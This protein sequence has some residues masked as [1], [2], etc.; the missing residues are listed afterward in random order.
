MQYLVTGGC[1]FI[2]SHFISLLLDKDASAELTNIDLLT[3]AGSEDNVTDAAASAG[4][5]YRFVKADIVDAGALRE[6]FEGS[7]F[8]AVINFAAESHVDRSIADPGSFVHTNVVGVANLIE[9]AREFG[10]GRRAAPLQFWCGELVRLRPAHRRDP[11]RD[12]LVHAP[13]APYSDPLQF[14]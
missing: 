6:V 9:L 13:R 10:V 12:W 1:G 7:R 8:D 5:R 3:Y 14:G 2:G 11:A 4:D